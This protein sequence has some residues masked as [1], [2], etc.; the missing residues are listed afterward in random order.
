MHKDV[1]AQVMKLSP[2]KIVYVSCIPF[3]LARD[4]G[5]MISAY[6]LI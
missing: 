6:E 2:E 5:E 4:I 1:L 3:T